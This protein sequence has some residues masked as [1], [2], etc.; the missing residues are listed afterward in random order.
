MSTFHQLVDPLNGSLALSAVLAALPLLLLF[1]MLGIF[2]T[3]AWKAAVASLDLAF[4]AYEA[5]HVLAFT[6][7]QNQ[8]SWRLMQRLG[9]RRRE[10]LDFIDTRFGPE[11]NPCIVYRIDAEEW[12]AARAA[13][14]S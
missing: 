8:P 3:K 12:P 9:M 13:A 1:V 2:R 10:D 14:L 7:T 5:P 6:V 11:L 4:G